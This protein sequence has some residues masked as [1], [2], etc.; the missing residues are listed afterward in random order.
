MNDLK[1]YSSM[2]VG[3][4]FIMAFKK[5]FTKPQQ[6]YSSVSQMPYDQKCTGPTDQWENSTGIS[7]GFEWPTGQSDGENRI[8]GNE[9][10]SPPA[11][12]RN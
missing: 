12:A 4:G 2:T 1:C 9:G 11:I 8:L 5:V 3:I 6:V 10:L 7:G